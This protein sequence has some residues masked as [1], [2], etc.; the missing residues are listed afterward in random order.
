[1]ITVERNVMHT[2]TFSVGDIL[3]GGV[4]PTYKEDGEMQEKEQL[5]Q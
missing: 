5:K 4:K 2:F 1:M 3:Y